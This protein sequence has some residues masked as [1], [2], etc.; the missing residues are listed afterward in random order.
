MKTKEEILDQ[1]YISPSDLKIL[2]PEIGIDR[3]RKYI[4][5]FRDEMKAKGLFVP[6][7]KPRVA[8]TK[9]VKEKLG[10]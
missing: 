6:E 7:T 8:L 10:L 9:L 2:I 1:L 3:C 4:K 5:E